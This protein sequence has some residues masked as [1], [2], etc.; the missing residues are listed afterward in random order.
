MITKGSV[1]KVCRICLAIISC[2]HELQFLTRAFHVPIISG[3]YAAPWAFGPGQSETKLWSL[4]QG[5][6]R[7]RHFE[8]RNESHM[9][10][11]LSEHSTPSEACYRSL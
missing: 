6:K 2:R 10:G 9:K 7:P 8:L 4:L 1:K 3:L 11:F 5:V